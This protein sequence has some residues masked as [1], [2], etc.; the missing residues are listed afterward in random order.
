MTTEATMKWESTTGEYQVEIDGEVI[1]RTANFDYALGFRNGFMASQ[2][3]TPE[4]AQ[5]KCEGVTS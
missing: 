1:S 3:I 5:C 2:I 4:A